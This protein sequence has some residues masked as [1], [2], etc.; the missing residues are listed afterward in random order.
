MVW[1]NPLCTWWRGPYSPCPFILILCPLEPSHA[2]LSF[3]A[4]PS[5]SETAWP[6]HRGLK[7]GQLNLLVPE[8]EPAGQRQGMAPVGKGGQGHAQSSKSLHLPSVFMV[9]QDCSE[10]LWIFLAYVTNSKPVFS[11]FSWIVVSLGDQATLG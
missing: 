3:P 2:W 7:G 8:K 6:F 10:G 11:M 9:K 1:V 5:L 4:L